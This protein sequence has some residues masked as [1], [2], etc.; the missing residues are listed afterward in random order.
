M[1]TTS[2]KMMYSQTRGQSDVAVKQ[3]SGRPLL[4]QLSSCSTFL[5]RIAFDTQLVQV[6]GTGYNTLRAHSRACQHDYG[7]TT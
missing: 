7:S 5:L 3:A 4:V 6:R 1:K 2:M